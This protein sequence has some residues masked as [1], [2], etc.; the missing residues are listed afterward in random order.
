MASVIARGNALAAIL[1]LGCYTGAD[2]GQQLANCESISKDG[3]QLRS[4]LV[5]K[6]DWNA[7]S[8]V[9]AS[10]RFQSYLDSLTLVHLREV[11]AIEAA[12]ESAHT[13]SVRAAVRVAEAR[14]EARVDRILA[15]RDTTVLWVHTVMGQEWINVVTD[16]SGRPEFVFSRLIGSGQPLPG[17]PVQCLV[18]SRSTSRQEIRQAM[19]W[20]AGRF[21]NEVSGALDGAEATAC[22][23]RHGSIK[24]EWQ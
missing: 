23:R 18:A 5:L 15:A 17:H 9:P 13:D 1:V 10:R 7:E 21:Y 20:S 3:D 2:R 4:C 12:A 22:P 16:R 6:Y 14:M 24:P 8:A 19:N 11:A